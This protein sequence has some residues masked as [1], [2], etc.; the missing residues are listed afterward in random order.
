LK[1]I[2]VDDEPL[3]RNEL[4]YLLNEIRTFDVINEAENVSE[5][6]E[7]LLYDRYDVIF[8]DINLMEESG[9]D[10]A[11]KINKMQNPPH[12]IFATAHDTFAVKAFEL[13]ATDYILKPFEQKRIAQAIHKVETALDHDTYKQA[14]DVSQH[15]NDAHKEN[16]PTSQMVLPIEVDE[17]I[18][19]INLEDIIAISVNNGITTINTLQEN[20]HTT[21]PL[22]HYE[23]KIAD[24]LFMRIHRA[25]L[26]NKLH[27][28]TIEH[29]FNYTYQ[30][31]MTNALKFQVSR[32]YM[33]TFK[34][35]MGLL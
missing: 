10:L 14:N 6:L 18:H 1:A 19:I 15:Q 34:Q 29:W 8:L 3:A 25:T 21:E 31:T 9:L 24:P 7:L 16:T 28:Q 30:L 4:H 33:K 22:N 35:N 27:I 2:I 26:V 20:Y 5:T 32:S 23:K 13:D 17:R 11:N 12:I